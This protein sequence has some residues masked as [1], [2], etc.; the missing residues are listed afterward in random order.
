MASTDSLDGLLDDG[1]LLGGLLDN[2]L[3]ED[4]LVSGLL[5]GVLG[6]DGLLGGVV[7]GVGGLLGGVLGGVGGLLDG[8]LGGLLGGGLNGLLGNLLG[9]LGDAGGLLAEL[10]TPELIGGVVTGLLGN[11]GGLLG[12]AIGGVPVG[13]LLD[14]LFGEG[15]LLSPDGLLGGLLGEDGLVTQLVGV[16]NN[17]GDLIGALLEPDGLLGNVTGLIGDVGNGLV[18]SGGLITSLIDGML[19]DVGGLFDDLSVTGIIGNLFDPDGLIGGPLANLGVGVDVGGVIGGV[20][21]QLPGLDALDSLLTDGILG[22]LLGDVLG[23]DGSGLTDLLLGA[24]GA[25]SPDVLMANI[26]DSGGVPGLLN[27][28]LDDGAVDLLDVLLTDLLGGALSGGLLQGDG[29]LI[30]N[31][32]SEFGIL[33]GEQLG[34]RDA[35]GDGLIGDVF[36]TLL[37]VGVLVVGS[38]VIKVAGPL[39]IAGTA[40]DLL[41]GDEGLL[42]GVVPEALLGQFFGENGVIGAAL[43]SLIGGVNG[44]DGLQ[45]V[46]DMSVTNIFDVVQDLKEVIAEFQDIGGGV[47]QLDALISLAGTL[48]EV[49][50]T[51][52]QV[53]T[54]LHAAIRDVNDI[55]VGTSGDDTMNGW[56]GDDQLDGGS[57]RDELSGGTGDDVMK[58]G[59]GNDYLKGGQGNDTMVAGAGLDAMNGGG[60][61]DTFRFNAASESTA[62]AE[63]DFISDFIHVEGDKIDLAAIDANT[64]VLGNQAFTYIGNQAFHNVAGELRFSG[65]ILAGDT[66]GDGR[67]DFEVFVRMHGAL[68]A[69]DFML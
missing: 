66:N 60:G 25:L 69:D 58:G 62:G 6:E 22:G 27:S 46:L 61:A 21:D 59:A 37:D 14:G 33:G 63:R 39:A 41:A 67:A 35:L 19:G 32:F 1:G 4:G 50:E 24:L 45:A 42:N 17:G 16:L 52:A 36:N 43:E 55:R 10:L 3:G 7:D 64:Q 13:D 5:G 57:G 30:G 8:L 29:G 15:G 38:E 44:R 28:V 68:V 31:F 18:G 40:A 23:P 26:V 47:P 20:F 34:L 53:F 48:E 49:A 12:G 9:E 11:L 2:L 54:D 65:S 56:L 51:S